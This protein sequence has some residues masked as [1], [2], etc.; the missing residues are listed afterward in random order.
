M[1]LQ[2][3]P[4]TPGAF[5]TVALIRAAAMALRSASALQERSRQASSSSSYSASLGQSMV[6]T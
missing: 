5:L 4:S 3:S 6:W 2:V 1:M